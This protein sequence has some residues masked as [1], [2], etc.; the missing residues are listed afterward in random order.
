MADEATTKEHLKQRTKDFAVRIIHV[1]RALPDARD[2]QVIG[3]QLLRCGTSVGAN[4]RAACRARSR[5]DFINKLG[6]VV[7]EADETIF[8]LELLVETKVVPAGR[9]DPLLQEAHELT[10][11]FTA[12]RATSRSG[13]NE[14]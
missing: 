11:I 7:E 12:A 3:N 1:F 8:W 14:I 5:A 2:A 6:I 9:L 13:R 4:Y 10:A